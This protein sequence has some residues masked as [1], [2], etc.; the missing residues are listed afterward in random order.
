GRCAWEHGAWVIRGECVVGL[1]ALGVGLRAP[2]AADRSAC[3]GLKDAQPGESLLE[4]VP[5]WPVDRAAQGWCAGV[6]HEAAGHGDE[7]L[8][9]GSG[10]DTLGG[11]WSRVDCHGPSDQVV[12]EDRALEPGAVGMEVSRGD[13]AQTRA[14]FEITDVEFDHSVAAVEGVKHHG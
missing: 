1:S 12:G 14:L 8:A 6:V 2:A 10:Y 4:P 7:L 5:P 3:C 9:D 13:V 11:G